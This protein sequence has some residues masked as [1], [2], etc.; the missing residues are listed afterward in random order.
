MRKNECHFAAIIIGG[1]PAGLA[2]AISAAGT[3]SGKVLLLE[4]MPAPGRKLLASGG[5][6]C[7][8][9]NILDS[10]EMAAAFGRK[11]RFVKPALYGFSPAQCRDFFADNGV[12]LTLTD[13]FHYFPESGKASSVLQGLLDAAAASGAG[14]KSPCRVKELILR[15]GKCCGVITDHGEFCADR[16]IIASGG[17]SYPQLGATGSGYALAAAAGHTIIPPLP[18][19]TGVHT[20]QTWCGEC[21]GIAL[22]DVETTIALPGEKERCRGEMIF[23]DAGIS[24]FAVLDISGRI[25]ELLQNMKSVPLKLN[26]FAGKNAAYWQNEF[27]LWRKNFPT[28]SVVRALNQYMPKKL[29]AFLVPDNEVKF[30]NLSKAMQ[31]EIITNLTALPLDAVACPWEKAMVT[32]GGVATTEIDP[33]TL[34]SKIVPNLFFAGEVIDVDGPCGGYNIQWALSSGFAA[35]SFRQ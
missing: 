5:G 33:H 7:N 6:R 34:E 35:G 3:A 18:A 12:P 21:A 1:G 32:R 8:V 28:R 19:M 9:T 24:A 30:A 16:V 15:D 14:I 13:G 25:S 2:A 11:Q 22:D 17:K 20:A 23:T 26:L 27:E 31:Q 10:A 4:Q 29:A